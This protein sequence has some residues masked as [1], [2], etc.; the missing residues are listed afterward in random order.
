[1]E[2]SP[3]AVCARAVG[4]DVEEHMPMANATSF[5]IGGPADLYITAPD[6]TAAQT[7]LQQCRARAV[8]VLLAGYGS[9]LL[10]S[11]AGIAGVVLRQSGRG[12]IRRTDGGRVVCGAGVSLKRLCMFARY[13]GLTGLET[14]YG[15]PGTVG[16]G[17]YMNAGAY[18]GEVADTLE[19]VQVVTA[20]GRLETRTAQEL[21]LGYRH[22]ALMDNGDAVV[23]AVF[24]LETE[25]QAVIAARMEEYMQRRR[26]KQPLEYPSAGSFFKRPTGYF[27]GAL[28]EQCGLKGFT[29]GGAQI[30]EKHAG[31]VINRGGATCVDVRR[32]AQE[33]HERV[34][35]A[36]GVSLEPEVRLVGRSE[37]EGKELAWNL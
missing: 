23:S 35:A 21:A 5:K 22:S 3:I 4:C 11:D 10:V 18:G 28:I 29:V 6:E 15:I 34:L 36:V 30:S 8:P 32:L 33:V 2:L 1:M 25:A 7:V 31:F 12:E 24:R 9:N 20:D 16:G 14:L 26:S 37:E 17:V 19:S 13:E 27:A